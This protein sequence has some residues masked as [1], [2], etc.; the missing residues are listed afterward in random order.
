MIISSNILFLYLR[1]TELQ[2]SPEIPLYQFI[3]KNPPKTPIFAGAKIQDHEGNPL[4]ILLVRPNGSLCSLPSTIKLELI[5]LDGDF[6]SRDD[7]TSEEFE[8][9]IVKERAGKRP[10]LTGDV[11][12]INIRGG[13]AVIGDLQFTDNSSWI[14]GRHFRVGVRVAPGGNNQITIKENMTERFTVKDHRGECEFFFFSPLSIS[15][16]FNYS[17]FNFYM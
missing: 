4:Q 8:R 6:P 13:V 5:P 3:F 14:R 10:L 16:G 15:R 2:I 17:V 1:Q 11:S 9:A 7:W 12:N